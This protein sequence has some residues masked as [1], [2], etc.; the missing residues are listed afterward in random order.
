MNT[1]AITDQVGMDVFLCSC[2]W[3]RA[4]FFTH[5]ANASPP[6]YSPILPAL[7]QL[8]YLP[9]QSTGHVASLQ[10][11]HPTAPS[12]AAPRLPF[13]V[14]VVTPHLPP[15]TA[16]TAVAAHRLPPLVAAATPRLPPVPR[17]RRS[18]PPSCVRRT[19]LPFLCP[20]L[21]EMLFHTAFANIKEFP[22]CTYSFN[23]SITACL[24][25]GRAV[26]VPSA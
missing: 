26:D 20:P 24:L 21:L 11:P 5:Q 10:C 12:T 14:A 15:A 9:S 2:V 23:S 16:V 3:K 1:E 22:F 7:A 19:R 8:L 18:S 4:Q 13:V 25:V 6:S 17:C